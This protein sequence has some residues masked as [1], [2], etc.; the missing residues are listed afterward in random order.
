MTL[1]QLN[2]P[3]G[4][5]DVR[6]Q[7][8]YDRLQKLLSALRQRDLPEALTAE[9]NQELRMLN[10]PK[11]SPAHLRRALVRHEL[12]ILRLVEK[13]AKLVPSGYYRQ[14]WTALGMSAF[15]L[16]LGVVFGLSLGNMALL[17]VGLPIGLAIG[18]AVG[19]GLD[20]KAAK[21][22]RQLIF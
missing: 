5:N 9:I 21:E 16:P 11:T 10:A 20:K 13:R 2:A 17:G 6:T 7:K 18:F 8:A 12:R 22:D 4:L 14:M 1:L 19:S 15:G 3:T